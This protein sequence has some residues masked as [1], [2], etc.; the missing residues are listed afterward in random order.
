MIIKK[1]KIEELD[2]I[3]EIYKN[4]IDLLNEK[5]IHQ[6]DE[7]Y[8]TKDIIE[9]DILNGQMYIGIENGKIVSAAV[10]NDDFDEQYINGNWLYDNFVVIHRVCVNPIYQNQKIGQRTMIMIEDLLKNK[11]IESIRLDAFSKNSHSLHMYEKLGY[12]KTGETNWRKGLFY[13]F[14]KNI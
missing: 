3:F 13:L 5:N 1:A 10:I 2:D 12:K 9:Q 11:G 4:S 8:P 14:E 7:I 6:W